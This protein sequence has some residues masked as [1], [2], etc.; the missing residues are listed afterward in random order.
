MAE[1]VAS[2]LGRRSRRLGHGHRGPGRRNRRE[3][4]RARV[5]RARR[6]RRGD[7]RRRRALRAGSARVDPG[8]GHRRPRST[9]CAEPP[10]SRADDALL[11][12]HRA[13]RRGARRARSTR[14]TTCAWRDPAW[15]RREVG[16]RREPP[17]HA[18][19]SSATSPTSAIAAL[20]RSLGDQLGG[21]RGVR[22]A[23]RRVCV[24]DAERAQGAHA[25]GAAADDP[26]GACAR[27]RL[28][29]SAAARCE[30]RR[31]C[32]RRDR[33][34]AARHARPR[35]QAPR[36]RGD[37]ADGGAGRRR[38]RT[39]RRSMSVRSATLF[40]STLTRRGARYE[41]LESWQL[42]RLNRCRSRV[43][44]SRAGIV[45]IEQVFV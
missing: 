29:T 6:S 24:A 18:R 33:F 3:A 8:A 25:L 2:A 10:R 20:R 12:R 41:A 5:V 22:A 26:E 30:L 21:V 27:S 7:R 15:A 4:G 17:R 45:D 34:T 16:R 44:P 19:R 37:R 31:R 13:A 11:R 35:A 38:G 42:P 23:V 40:S 9:C 28:A 32:S 1:G 39:C 36:S 43:R 14:A